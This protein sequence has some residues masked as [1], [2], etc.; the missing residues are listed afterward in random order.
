MP[1][2]VK[3]LGYNLGICWVLGV[4]FSLGGQQLAVGRVFEALN[5]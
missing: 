3:P 2:T 5:V 4:G 1:R